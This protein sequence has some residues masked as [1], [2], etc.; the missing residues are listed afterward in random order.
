MKDEFFRLDDQSPWPRERAAEFD[1]LE[2]FEPNPDLVFDVL[3]QVVEPTEIEAATSTG[4]TR[5]YMRVA[6]ATFEV[7]SEPVTVDL[8][9][10]GGDRLFLPFRDATSGK[11]SYGSGRY[12]DLYANETGHVVIDFNYAYAPYCAYSDAY[13]CTLPPTQNWLNVPIRAGERTVG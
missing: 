1:G 12:L 8:L 5:T 9:S 7:E 6:T 4:D 10:S 11:E 2:Y 13:S 3:P